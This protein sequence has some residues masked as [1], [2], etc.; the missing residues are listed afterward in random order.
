MI[1]KEKNGVKFFQFN[2]INETGIVNH[3]FSTRIGGVSK[4]QWSSM[5]LGFSRGDNPEHVKENFNIMCNALNVDINKM[6]S[7]NQVHDNKIKVANA[8]DRSLSGFDGYVTNVAGLVL[9]TFHADCVPIFFVDPE[10]KAIGLCHSG[11]RGTVKS[12]SKET[13]NTMVKEYGSTIENIVVAIGPSI[14]GCCFQVEK[15]VVDEF[16][17]TFGFAKE[18]IKPDTVEGKYKIDLWEINK[19]I[20]INSGVLEKNIEVTDK[21]TMCDTSLFYS[22][23]KEGNE[24]GSLAAF[25]SLKESL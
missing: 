23:R 6:V 19:Q 20:L 7:G 25:L 4:D 14:G 9:V 21:C 13:I 10:K 3:G 1:L 12:I 8:P 18:F 5:N 2:N 11:W 22:H 24:R 16:N 17:N 15:P